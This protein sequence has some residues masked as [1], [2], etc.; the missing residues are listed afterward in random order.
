MDTAAKIV[1]EALRL[2]QDEGLTLPEAVHRARASIPASPAA[3]TRASRIVWAT[4]PRLRA[5]REAAIRELAKR[6]GGGP[7]LAEWIGG[8]VEAHRLLKR[9]DQSPDRRAATYRVIAN[10][11]VEI[12]SRLRPNVWREFSAGFEV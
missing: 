11:E 9:P 3:Q 7:R 8:W 5:R 12:A 10:M 1:T 4:V 2:W 6:L